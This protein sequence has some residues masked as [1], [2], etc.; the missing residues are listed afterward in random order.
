MLRMRDGARG[1]RW[2]VGSNE[3]SARRFTLKELD[4]SSCFRPGL[5]GAA[6]A[7]DGKVRQDRPLRLQN[8]NAGDAGRANNCSR[9][10]QGA[11]FTSASAEERSARR[12]ARQKASGN[13]A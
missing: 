2:P 4:T 10:T 13:T 11:D 3:R 9:L 12:R 7:A 8:I 1:N 6:V 5:T